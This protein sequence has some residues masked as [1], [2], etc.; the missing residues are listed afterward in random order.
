[1]TPSP[2][3]ATAA[4]G[5]P[6]TAWHAADPWTRAP[7]SPSP[8]PLRTPED[9]HPAPRPGHQLP[10]TFTEL[11]VSDPETRA[12]IAAARA[13]AAAEPDDLPRLLLVPRIGGR[14]APVGTLAVVE[15]E[16]RLP[17]GKPG[18]VLRGLSRVTIGPG[19]VG[20]GA[21]L[22]VHG[23]SAAEP[24]VGPGHE[25]A[26]RGRLTRRPSGVAVLGAAAPVAVVGEGS[27]ASV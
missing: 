13:A 15:Q 27:D 21:A 12:S 8:I 7:A 14:Y 18:A 10:V 3:R 25:L 1:M 22:R 19:P 20:P 6:P 16:G 23:P 4:G 17:N 9:R 2:R 5:R 11:D 24:L 26:G